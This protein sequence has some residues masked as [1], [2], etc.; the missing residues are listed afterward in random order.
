MFMV[1]A[2][3]PM[4]NHGLLHHPHQI[5]CRRNL[6]L[7]AE[8]AAVQEPLKKLSTASTGSLGGLRRTVS[9]LQAVKPCV[10]DAV[11]AEKCVCQAS[12]VEIFLTTTTDKP[13][14]LR[15]VAPNGESSE[16][17][18]FPMA[19]SARFSPRQAGCGH[20]KWTFEIE[21]INADDQ[22]AASKKA[23]APVLRTEIDL[24]GV[25]SLFYTV[26]EQLDI[27]LKG[28]EWIHLPSAASACR[29]SSL[30]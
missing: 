4:L 25:G 7:E 28:Q 5:A 14:L 17:F 18:F 16:R 29:N 23:D 10:F 11:N 15:V 22:Q 1:S 24:E 30:N 6:K 13:F 19:K 27:T 26:N 2:P 9:S 20:G 3:T 8:E 12:Q 21:S